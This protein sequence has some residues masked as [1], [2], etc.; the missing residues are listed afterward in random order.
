MTRLS[1]LT[2]FVVCGVI[3]VW[4]PEAAAQTGSIPFSVVG[5]WLYRDN[6]TEVILECTSDGRFQ[7]QDRTAQGTR[8][9]RGVYRVGPNS[10]EF[11]PDG[12][13]TI[14]RL[15][16][17]TPDNN[18]LR[19]FFPDGSVLQLSRV[20]ATAAGGAQG[21]MGTVPGQLTASPPMVRS[22][23][24][25]TASPSSGGPL[26]DPIPPDVAAIAEN[27][28]KFASQT[29][30]SGP[31]MIPDWPIIQGGWGS[32]QY[33]PDW[34]IKEYG[35]YAAHVH[36]KRGLCHAVFREGDRTSGLPTLDQLAQKVSQ[37]LIGDGPVRVI[38]TGKWAGMELGIV[39]DDSGRGQV[40][41]F[42]WL[43]PEA[44]KMVAYLAIRIRS[45]LDMGPEWASTTFMFV[46]C[47]CPE[48]E[49]RKWFDT[50]FYR[51]GAQSTVVP[52]VSGAK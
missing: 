38:M 37:R 33:P 35:F 50:V 22:S 20:Q 47:T 46:F 10:I 17:Q 26:N 4:M 39:D 1:W 51:S 11:L 7:R 41:M 16:C 12:E 3:A 18:T 49:A 21:G 27:L 36:D 52:Q 30:A 23:T 13:Y 31:P 34:V 14:T 44:G 42:R 24:G 25:L 2:G 29:M 6:Q 28:R 15:Q 19:L 5:T 45:R 40:W 48:A 43:H 32:F 8:Q 9:V